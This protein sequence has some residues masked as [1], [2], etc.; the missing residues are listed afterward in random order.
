MSKPF[1]VLLE[2]HFGKTFRIKRR[3]LK[4]LRAFEGG[5]F[6]SPIFLASFIASSIELSSS[7]ELF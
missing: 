4:L 3:V 6:N 1:P 2:I 7:G 5:T